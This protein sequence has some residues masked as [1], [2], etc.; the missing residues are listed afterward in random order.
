MS[1]TGDA[2]W[3][4]KRNLYSFF[5]NLQHNAFDR[6]FVMSSSHVSKDLLHLF[7]ILSPHVKV[8]F[9]H[10]E[11]NVYFLLKVLTFLLCYC[12]FSKTKT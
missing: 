2:D 3:P 1:D 12:T 11:H 5:Q 6:N 8:S 9:V 10:I 7:I 4:A